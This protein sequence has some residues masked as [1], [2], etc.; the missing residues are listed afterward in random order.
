MTQQGLGRVSIEHVSK[1]YPSGA[2]QPIHILS[3]IHLS[4][5]SGEFISIVGPKG[6]GK[7]TLLRLIVGLENQYQGQILIDDEVSFGKSLQCGLLF[8]DNRLFPWLS[9]KENIR[10]ALYK[11]H[12]SRSEEDQLIEQYLELLSL[13]DFRNAYPTQLSESMNQ[14]VAIA[15]SLV[16]KPKLLL[17]D[18]PFKGLDALNRQSLQAE[19]Q[20]IWQTEKITVI[21]VTHDLDEAVFL[22]QKVIVLHGQPGQVKR[23]IDIPIPYPRKRTDA[24]LQHLKFIVLNEMSEPK[25]KQALSH[26]SKP[27][28]AYK[29]AW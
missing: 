3:D 22:S 6:C 28:S 15:R 19:L 9:V 27:F 12:L 24:R 5:Q 4:I 11:N 17:L 16:N 1:A 14:K 2:Q 21:H 23:S 7:S 26:K 25:L 8:Q 13:S 29:F 10:S 20:R 18:D